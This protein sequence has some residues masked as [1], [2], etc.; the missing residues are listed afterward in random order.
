M[1]KRIFLY[2]LILLLFIFL[3]IP[4]KKVLAEEHGFEWISFLPIYKVLK[5]KENPHPQLFDI[6]L[7]H[8]YITTTPLIHGI[9]VLLFLISASFY[10]RKSIKE[11]SKNLLPH[12]KLTF[13]NLFELLINLIVNIV[14]E[15]MGKEGRRF[16]PLLCSV[17][18]FIFFSNLLGLIPGFSAPTSDINT[19]LACA[20][21]V[22]FSY[23]YYG[24]KEHGIKYIKQF[25]G[26]I[27]AISWLMFP[28]EIIGHLSR[29]LSLSVRLFGNIMGDHK[30]LV[31]FTLLVPYIIPVPF[32]MLGLFVAFLQAFIFTMLSMVYLAGAVSHE[33]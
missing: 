19:N 10:L 2:F 11:M 18:I 17:F 33:H 7:T 14:D 12:S 16:I 4:C 15:N 30:I 22:F 23:H 26:P 32:I 6:D 3:L 13:Y 1:S 29:P 8:K 28:I 24:I 21:V 9:I 20:I 27:W 25:T 5:A 31:I